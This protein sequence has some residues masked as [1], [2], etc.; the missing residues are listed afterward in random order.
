MRTL[1]IVVGMT[2]SHRINRM[3]EVQAGDGSSG[4]LVYV[5]VKS[6]LGKGCSEGSVER[7]S[8]NHS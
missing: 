6:C 1:A 5:A 4:G 7:M 8:M 2:V 3:T